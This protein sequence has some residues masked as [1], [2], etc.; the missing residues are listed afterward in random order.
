VPYLDRVA[1][2]PMVLAFTSS[3]PLDTAMLGHLRENMNGDVV[4]VPAAG[5]PVTV[6]YSLN[7]FGAGYDALVEEQARRNSM[8]NFLRG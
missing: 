1:I 5:S 4:V 8:W 2:D 3:A 7:G 6:P